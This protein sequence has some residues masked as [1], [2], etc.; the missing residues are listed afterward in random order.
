L[1][2][3]HCGNQ[4][5]S[6]RITGILNIVSDIVVLVLPLKYLLGLQVALYRK[7]VLVTAFLLGVL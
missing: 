3:G 6:F 4:I 2:G 5:L 1:P 7:V